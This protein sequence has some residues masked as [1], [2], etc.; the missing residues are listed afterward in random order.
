[1]ADR[2]QLQSALDIAAS[3]PVALRDLADRLELME[4]T[5]RA[6]RTFDDN[7]ADGYADCFI[8]DGLYESPRIGLRAEGREAL[9]AM[10]LG[11]GGVDIHFVTNI[12]IELQ[13]D[14]ARVRCFLLLSSR[15]GPLVNTTGRY[16]NVCVRTDKGWRYKSKT[17]YLDRRG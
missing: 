16:E 9:K 5:A 13:G 14:E 2:D 1:M 7:D 11:R 4:L 6:G 17:S 15:E 10:C 12:E 8:D 3:S